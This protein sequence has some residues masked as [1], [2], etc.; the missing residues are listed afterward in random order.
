[1]EQSGDAVASSTIAGDASAVVQTT[2]R[3]RG[4]HRGDVWRTVILGLLC[5]LMIAPLIM[6]IF[7]S[8][9]SPS[10]FARVPFTPTLVRRSA[11]RRPSA[12]PLSWCLS[13]CSRS[14]WRANARPSTPI[15]LARSYKLWSRCPRRCAPRSRTKTTSPRWLAAG[16][17]Q[18][19]CC[20]SVA[21]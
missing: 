16:I 2:G 10:Q 20:S 12:S 21:G 5:F 7:I 15:V 4:L 8:F 3:R 9:K 6:A 19:T 17:T 14:T 11:S 13:C 1:M 18:N